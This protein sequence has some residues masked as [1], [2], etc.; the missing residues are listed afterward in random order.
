M[1]IS[2]FPSNGS[3]YQIT[4]ETAATDG[5]QYPVLFLVHGN[6]GLSG[7]LGT[8]IRAFASSLTAQGYNTAIPQ[9]YLDDRPHYFDF[10]PKPDIL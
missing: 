5:K 1:S 6:A 7:R 8:Q 3:T 2:T 4:V 9:Y 10:I